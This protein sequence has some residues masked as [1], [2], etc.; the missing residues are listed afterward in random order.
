MLPKVSVPMDFGRHLIGSPT[1]SNLK[2]NTSEGGEVRASSVILSFNSPVIDHMTTTLHMTSV[3]MLEFSKPAVQLLVDAAYSGTAEGITRELFRDINKMANVFEV[4]WL[5]N[6]CAEYFTE[7][8]DS[9]NTPSYTELLYLFEEAGFVYE[10]LKIRDYLNLTIKKIEIM[11]WK[12]KFIERYLE[13]ADRLSTQKL[14]MVIELAGSEVNCVVQTLTN[15]LSE[16]LKVQ[17]FSLSVSCEYLLENS[18]LYLCKMSDRVLFDNLFEVLGEVPDDKLRWTFE[19]IRKYS[20]QRTEL[21][22]S[23]GESSGSSSTTVSRCNTI[24][25]LYHDID[26]NMSFNQLLDWL[27]VSEDVTSLLMAI[28]AVCTWNWYRH[29]NQSDTKKKSCNVGLSVLSARLTD[30]VEERGWCLLPSYFI[31]YGIRL[32]VNKGEF[33]RYDLEQ[34]YTANKQDNSHCTVIDCINTLDMFCKP[35][36]SILS[37][38]SKLIYLFQ[39][40]SVTS[41]SLPGECGFI[42]KTVPSEAA[43]WTLRL[44]TDREDYLGETV[45]FHDEIRAEKMHVFITSDYNGEL[46]PLSWLGWLHVKD[47]HEKAASWE[48]SND[49]DSYINIYVMYS[50]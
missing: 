32:M 7:E 20:K 4:S 25:N 13:N 28:E 26:L 1:H 5:A 31:N 9:F 45:H 37:K 10:K 39:H 41:C 30:L 36:S 16:Q 40:P 24:P 3:D 42:L 27:S 15:Q 43:L 19:L 34:F 14:D 47:A 46:F 48:K 11:K 50:E 49:P 35:L 22:H 44:C 6:K 8:A 2:L 29:D 12:Q 33:D 23:S 17:G 18:D 21:A 38:D